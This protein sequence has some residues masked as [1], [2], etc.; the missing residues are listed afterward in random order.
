MSKAYKKKKKT[1]SAA[2]L[3]N[4]KNSTKQQM[5]ESLLVCSAS[6]EI[7]REL[8]GTSPSLS[9]FLVVLVVLVGEHLCSNA[10]PEGPLLVVPVLTE[11]L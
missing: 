3:W 2:C 11:A 7:C 6:K 8:M 9:S 4:P 10:C 5:S 1:I